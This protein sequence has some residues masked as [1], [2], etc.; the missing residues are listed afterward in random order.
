MR[1]HQRAH[2][3]GHDHVGIGR[4]R[5]E[6]KPSGAAAQE[7]CHHDRGRERAPRRMCR[8]PHRRRARAHRRFDPAREPRRRRFARQPLGDRAPQ[9]L[10][11]FAFRRQRR[12]VRKLPLEFE[13]V[14]RIE[15]AVDIGVYEQA[16]IGGRS[17]HD[18]AFS[19]S[20]ASRC[21]SRRRARASRDITVPI[22]TLVTSA[23]SR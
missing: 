14:G 7:R 15:L 21:I 20:S 23:I 19:S 9:R 6:R 8:Y 18:P 11:P 2:V 4:G 5:G 10:D 1:R 3:I 17:C 16:R 22:G 13:R 12:I